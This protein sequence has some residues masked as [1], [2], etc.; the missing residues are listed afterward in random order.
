MRF[1]QVLTIRAFTLKEIWNG[2]GA[3]TIDAHIQPEARDVHH[4]LL[5]LGV[6]KIQVRLAGIK[7]VP[8]ILSRLFIPRPIGRL[9]I[10]K[11]NTGVLIF[12]IGI[13]PYV[14]ISVWRVA[15]GA[16]GFEPGMLVGGVIQHE[17]RND[18]NISIVCFL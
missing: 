17:V 1:R 15:I 12:L 11:D 3:E 14:I 5:Y 18:A 13:A 10:E 9:G 4:F 16:R 6:I 8:V 2:V 7:T